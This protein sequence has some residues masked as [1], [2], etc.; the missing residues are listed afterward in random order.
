MIRTFIAVFAP[1][2]VSLR[3]EDD[4]REVRSF[5]SDAK[6]VPA[7]RFHFTLRFLGNLP[8]KGW[9]C[10]PSAWQNRSKERRPL[11]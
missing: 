8:R 9:T 2:E 4:T 5:A 1:K 11:R 7:D 3:V 6:W 10:W